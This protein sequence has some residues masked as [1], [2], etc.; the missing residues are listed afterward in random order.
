MAVEVVKGMMREEKTRRDLK[1]RGTRERDPY[2]FD[3]KGGD[4]IE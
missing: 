3:R 4:A 1:L 2:R